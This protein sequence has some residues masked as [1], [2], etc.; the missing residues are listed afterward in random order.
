MVASE[1][2]EHVANKE[3]FIKACVSTLK[4]GGRIF[5]TTPTR[6]RWTQVLGI[7]VS[8]YVLGVVPKGTHQ[9]EKLTTP[10]E[11]TFLLER[12]KLIF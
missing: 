4:P 7:C 10:N 9:Y 12:S 8:E 6:S 1:I 3:L 5:I 11:V 2:I